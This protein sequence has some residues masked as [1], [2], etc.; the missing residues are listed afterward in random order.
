MQVLNTVV[1]ISM[2]KT[3]KYARYM[4]LNIKIKYIYCGTN[5]YVSTT[6]FITQGNM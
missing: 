1:D 6:V 2:Y 4:Y 5:L 3:I